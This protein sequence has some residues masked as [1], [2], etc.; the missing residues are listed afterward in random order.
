MIEV[1]RQQIIGLRFSETCCLPAGQWF[2]NIL[3][4]EVKYDLLNAPHHARHNLPRLSYIESIP[5]ANAVRPRI[6]LHEIIGRASL[7]APPSFASIFNMLLTSAN[8]GPGYKMP[9]ATQ[10]R[11]TSTRVNS[12]HMENLLREVEGLFESQLSVES[13]LSLSKKLQVELRQ[14]MVSSL[15]CMLPSFNYTLPTGQEQGTYLA[16]EVGGSNLR[17]ALLKLRGR[18]LGTE[19][20]RVRRTTISP[21]DR[22]VRQLQKYA[23]FD[24]MAL[25]IKE[26]LVLEGENPDSLESVE[27]L[28]MGVAWSFPIESA[29]TALF[30]MSTADVVTVKL[31]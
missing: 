11:I 15:Q 12:R 6:T 27:P 1:L 10:G 20:M 7:L 4:S 30:P 23:F 29:S 22:G 31:L 18:H 9:A 19:C 24:W 5:L 26:M 13:L 3:A 25:Q 21:I 2:Y 28:R 8:P 16:L 17:M 14:H